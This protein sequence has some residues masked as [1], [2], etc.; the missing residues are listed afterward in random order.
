M[1]RVTTIQV[2][3]D[4]KLRLDLIGGKGDSYDDII[5]R[6]LRNYIGANVSAKPSNPA[7]N[8]ER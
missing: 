4:T 3:D 2:K 8:E 1:K 5:Q 6:L 7:L